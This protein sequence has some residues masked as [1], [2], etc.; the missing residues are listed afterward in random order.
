M[1]VTASVAFWTSFVPGLAVSFGGGKHW[2]EVHP[3]PDRHGLR[4]CLWPNAQLSVSCAVGLLGIVVAQPKQIRKFFLD[5]D[6]DFGLR[7]LFGKPLIFNA[8]PGKLSF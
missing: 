5:V 2:I 8:Q 3:T 6:D 7:Q 4:L 1:H